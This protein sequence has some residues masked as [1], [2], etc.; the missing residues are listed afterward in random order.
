MAVLQ[1]FTW[2]ASN[3]PYTSPFSILVSG[4][5][6]H[7]RHRTISPGLFGSVHQIRLAAPFTSTVLRPRFQLCSPSPSPQPFSIL[8]TSIIL[9]PRHLNHS[10]SSSPEPFSILVTELF[11]RD[12]SALFIRFVSQPRSP[13]PSSVHVFSSV[14][15]LRHLNHSP[16]S[17]P[18][19][20]SILV[21]S[22]ILHPRHLNRPPSSFSALFTGFVSGTVLCPVSLL[23]SPSS[24]PEPF[25]ILVFS[26]VHRSRLRNRPPSRL[27]YHPPS[28][29][30]ALFTGFVSGTVLHPRLQNRPPSRLRYRPPSSSPKPSSIFVFSRPVF[31]DVTKKCAKNRYL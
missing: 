1:G 26:S 6:L 5:V 19:S 29:F 23:R 11:H 21:T 31:L 17:S 7:P 2:C 30:S 27:R 4:T 12:Y 14:L 24:S 3:T 18:Q 22:T 25:S 16:S 9:H 13:Q 8:V 20:F 15:R 28:S 10:P